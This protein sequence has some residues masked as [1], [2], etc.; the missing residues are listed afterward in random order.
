MEVRK[1]W[2]AHYSANVMRAAL[3]SRHSLDEL[4][5]FARD[6]FAGIADKRLEAPAFSG[7]H[8]LTLLH[9]FL[10]STWSSSGSSSDWC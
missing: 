1:F 6:K 10:A 9:H 7:S 3:V 2:E 5:A 4:E 8:S